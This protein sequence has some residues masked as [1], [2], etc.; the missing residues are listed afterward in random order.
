M[1][2]IK[3]VAEFEGKI[4]FDGKAIQVMLPANENVYMMLTDITGKT[5]KTV[6]L[7]GESNVVSVNAPKGIYIVRLTTAKGVYSQKISL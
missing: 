2:G 1:A 3:P 6:T 7:W 4:Y 5:I